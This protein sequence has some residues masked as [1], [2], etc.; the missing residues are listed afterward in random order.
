MIP[1]NDN[2]HAIYYSDYDEEGMTAGSQYAKDIYFHRTETFGFKFANAHPDPQKP[3]NP[4]HQTSNKSAIWNKW[5]E[6]GLNQMKS[7]YH[8]LDAKER[9]RRVGNMH[10]LGSA[11][12]FWE[13]IKPE[14]INP[15]NK[16]AQ[17]TEFNDWMIGYG[18]GKTG[19]E[20]DQYSL[21]FSQ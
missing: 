20:I 7:I 6:R 8:V 9:G 17:E 5:F 16:T 18:D 13:S 3:P 14:S 21:I 15:Y 10:A 1:A 2:D 11:S 12:E 19:Q 4:H